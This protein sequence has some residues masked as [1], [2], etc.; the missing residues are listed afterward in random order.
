MII[1]KPKYWSSSS[2]PVASG[3]AEIN[4]RFSER[5]EIRSKTVGRQVKPIREVQ[6]TAFECFACEIPLIIMLFTTKSL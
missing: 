4:D 3:F 2:S 1:R 5:F 6:N